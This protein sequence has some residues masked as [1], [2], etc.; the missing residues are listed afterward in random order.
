MIGLVPYFKVA[1]E[2]LLDG[3]IQ[4]FAELYCVLRGEH[5]LGYEL[6][7]LSIGAHVGELNDY[8]VI[9]HGYLSSVYERSILVGGSS[10]GDL[11]LFHRCEDYD[12]T[13]RKASTRPAITVVM[14]SHPSLT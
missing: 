2:M 7:N 11:F 9:R 13:L 3:C 1:S 8:S 4:G 12:N 5:D 6:A 14:I 10:D